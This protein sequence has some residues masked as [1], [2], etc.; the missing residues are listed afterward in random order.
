[1][2]PRLAIAVVAAASLALGGCSA[3]APISVA[4]NTYPSVPN[5]FA[6]EVNLISAKPL[7]VWVH[8]GTILALI[9]V[10]IVACTP[11]PTAI[12]ATDDTT[13][14]LTFVKSPNTPCQGNI[15]PTT[16]EFRIPPGIDRD[17]STIVDIHFDIPGAEDYAVEV[18]R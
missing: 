12:T 13:I 4:S 10:G 18:Q 14:A 8:G 5:G 1:M 6:Q 3:G 2:I 15:G 11:V 9:T 7:A 17:S 16:H